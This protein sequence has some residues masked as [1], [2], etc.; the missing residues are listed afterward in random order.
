MNLLLTERVG[1]SGKYWPE[2][3]AVRTERFS[4]VRSRASEVSKLFIIFHCFSEISNTS[5]GGF[6]KPNSA[7]F[8]C[9]AQKHKLHFLFRFL[10]NETYLF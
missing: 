3:V 4:L 2:V 6:V 7:C 9:C 5:L 1:L 8:N 10:R